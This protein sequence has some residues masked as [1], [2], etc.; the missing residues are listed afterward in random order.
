M[1]S[2]L[3]SKLLTN[4]NLKCLSKACVV[5]VF[6]T[7]LVCSASVCMTFLEHYT[8]IRERVNLGS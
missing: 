6:K 5:V 7:K 1:C 3:L 4:N 8:V 2:R